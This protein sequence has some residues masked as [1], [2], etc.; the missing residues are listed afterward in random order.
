MSLSVI[1]SVIMFLLVGLIAGYIARL[2]VPGPDPMGIVGTLLLGIVGSYIGGFLWALFAEG[3]LLA[4]SSLLGSIL[5][6]VIA[7]LIYRVIGRRPRRS[8]GRTWGARRP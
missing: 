7:L 8:R 5:G 4:R 1:L 2:V 6:A 3:E